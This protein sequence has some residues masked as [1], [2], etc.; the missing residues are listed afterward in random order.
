VSLSEGGPG[1]FLEI[2]GQDRRLEMDRLER[3]VA[4]EGKASEIVDKILRSY[5]FEPDVNQ[6]PIEYREED[7]TLNQ[8]GTDLAFVT[9]LAGRSDARF[10]I[11]CDVGQGPAGLEIKEI[12]HFRPSPSRGQDTDRFTASRMLLAPAGAPEIR[13]NNGDGCS[14][15]TG[16]ELKSTAEAPNQSGQINR[17][18]A[19]D[20]ESD[21]TEV[22]GTTT[23]PLGEQQPPP[24]PRTRRLVTAGDAQEA[25]LRNRAALNDASWSVNAK[26]ETSAHALGG[27]LRAHDIVT[28][29]GAGKL[30]SGDYF[31]KSVTHHI[32]PVDHKMTVEL[33]RN[34]LGG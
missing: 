14:N 6:T 29:T 1:S 16:F 22:P 26:V 11:T 21:D 10:W 20:G 4:H 13:L 32:N 31:V 9:Q 8:T 5:G 19:D 28:V 2:Q 15:A 24:M 30:N 17:I 23:E 7:H 25:Q 33:L 18:N 12:A 3:S 34:S 27:V